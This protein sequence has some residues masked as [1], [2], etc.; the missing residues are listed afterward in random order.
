MSHAR[1]E[2]TITVAI[3]GGFLAIGVP[4]LKRGADMPAPVARYLPT[5]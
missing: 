4:C 2:Y 5:I 3:I 1:P